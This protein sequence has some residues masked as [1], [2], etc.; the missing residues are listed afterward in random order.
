MLTY[1]KLYA[2]LLGDLSDAA[3]LLDEGRY[4]EACAL[5]K[6]ACARAEECV[7]DAEQDIFPDE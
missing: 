5:L 3:E 7:L 4:D 6:A 2:L 1:K